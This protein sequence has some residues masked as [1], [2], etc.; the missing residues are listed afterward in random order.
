MS[1]VAVAKVVPEPLVRVCLAPKVRTNN[2]LEHCCRMETD[3]TRSSLGLISD[4][5]SGVNGY[6][7]GKRVD[8]SLKY[9]RAILPVI[10]LLNQYHPPSLRNKKIS[11]HKGI[12]C[13]TIF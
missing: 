7:S 4:L 1:A 5:A 10:L 13:R 12:L 11:K 3:K 6:L 9:V 8:K 2:K